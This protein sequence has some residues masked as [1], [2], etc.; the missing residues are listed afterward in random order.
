MQLAIKMYHA[1]KAFMYSAEFR[2]FAV[3]CA[4]LTV[5]LCFTPAE[6]HAISLP[7]NKVLDSLITEMQGTVRALAILGVMICA[8]GL[9]LGNAG[10]GMR[11][12]LIIMLAICIGAYATT[13]V[14]SIWPGNKVT[15]G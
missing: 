11:K 10:D 14:D 9:F 7:W 3:P 15:G 13:M 12:F 6:S 5:A 1:C 4:M 2:R 8:I